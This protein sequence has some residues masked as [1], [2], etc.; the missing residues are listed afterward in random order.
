[1]TSSWNGGPP[2]LAHHDTH[3]Y[4]FSPPLEVWQNINFLLSPQFPRRN[5][6]NGP[7]SIP[8]Y[9]RAWEFSVHSVVLE[10]DSFVW[11]LG[12]WPS[13]RRG[14]AW[15]S[16]HGDFW[17]LVPGCEEEMFFFFPLFPLWGLHWKDYLGRGRPVGRAEQLETPP[18]F[19]AE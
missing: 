14:A 7:F 18:F 6:R 19:V 16:G 15:E 2:Q 9:I 3:S 1:L 8:I 5:L 17:F 10:T 11:V 4:P 13:S 12:D